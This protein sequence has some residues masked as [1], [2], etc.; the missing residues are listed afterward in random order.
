M[1]KFLTGAEGG[2]RTP[3]SCLTRPSNV[4]VCQFRHFGMKRGFQSAAII[5]GKNLTTEP[6]GLPQVKLLVPLVKL[7]AWA[8]ESVLIQVPVLLPTP[9]P[10]ES[11]SD[12][13]D[14]ASK[15]ST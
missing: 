14:R 6:T 8:L 5:A 10:I 7:V 11:R 9:T 2:T 3:T 12:R 4:R 15:R 13:E 1:L